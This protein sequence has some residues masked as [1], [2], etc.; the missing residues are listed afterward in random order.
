MAASKPSVAALVEQ[1][2]ETDNDIKAKQEEAGA[3][4]QVDAPDK[5][6]RKP[7]R[8]GS[9]S[10]FTGPDPGVA[11][12]IFTEILSGG[13]ESITELLELVRE[14][15]DPD[16][17]NYK[18]GYVLHGLVIL[19]GRSGNAAQRRL[20]ADTL[21]SQLTRDQHSQAVKGFF[22]REL[23]VVGDKE[24]ADSLGRHL[25]D[26]ELCGDAT[27]ALLTIREG[28]APQFR[29]ALK[30]AQGKNRVTILHALGV[31]RDTSSGPALKAALTDTDPDVRRTAAWALANVG[32][33][34][35][36]DALLESADTTQGWE[37]TEATRHCLL[38]AQRLAEAGKKPQA[39][40]IY[41]HLR[42]TRRDPS[43]RH[44]RTAAERALG[45]LPE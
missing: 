4:P 39:I 16:Y 14:P 19:V 35:A 38:L 7:E 17:K 36:V 21:A 20:I 5:P 15:S 6:N 11:E 27:Q 23:R 30:K 42:D 8:L 31:L 12:K 32:E 34:S 26:D 29:A 37:R 13:R 22:I 24:S 10:K 1:M 43:E 2:P 45:S 41:G 25:L 44:V 9:A 40:R 3:Q 33:V 18:A 28:A